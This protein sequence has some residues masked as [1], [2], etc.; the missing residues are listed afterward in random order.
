MI[1][2]LSDPPVVQFGDMVL[3]RVCPTCRRFVKADDVTEVRRNFDESVVF[4]KSNATCRQC[5]RVKMEF[6]CFWGSGDG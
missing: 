6:V 3:A 2:E 1:D 4:E 5:G